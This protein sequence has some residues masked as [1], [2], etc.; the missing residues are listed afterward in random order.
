MN[1]IGAAAVPASWVRHCCTAQDR[2][3][4]MITE[5]RRFKPPLFASC[6]MGYVRWMPSHGCGEKTGVSG[7]WNA[8]TY[9]MAHASVAAIPLAFMVSTF[10]C[11][12]WKNMRETFLSCRRRRHARQSQDVRRFH[13]AFKAE[14][15]VTA[16]D[17]SVLN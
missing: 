15:H 11:F 13:P 3:A 10:R 5:E 12:L 6:A 1:A 2:R 8:A 17:M 14:L 4:R 7:P 9:L 16:S